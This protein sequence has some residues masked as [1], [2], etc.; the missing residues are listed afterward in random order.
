[1]MENR[2][3]EEFSAME[4]PDMKGDI[5]KKIHQEKAVYASRKLRPAAVI[6]IAAVMVVLGVTA[7]AAVSG[8][9]NVQSGGKYL[10]KNEYGVVVNP[11]GYHLE[12]DVAYPFSEAAR[13]NMAQYATTPE[14]PYG[15]YEIM[16]ETAIL[17][18]IETFLDLKLHLPES[19]AN[20]ANLFRFSGAGAEG[21]DRSMC[22]QIGTEASVDVMMVWLL[23]TPG[24]IGT[25]SEPEMSEYTLPDGTYVSLVVAERRKGG[26]VAHALYKKEEAV[27]QLTLTGDNKKDLLTEIKA[28]LDTVK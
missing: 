17:Q 10:L 3:K 15:R 5:M 20:E 22:L 18:E 8:K 6:V 27:Y 16:Y 14:G 28:V 2:L 9:L 4:I 26:L 24:V 11:T 21:E 23:D 12:E 19:V 13:E 25:A 1:M 7:G